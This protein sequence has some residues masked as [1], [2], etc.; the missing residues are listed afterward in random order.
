MST[1]NRPIVYWIHRQ[2][3]VTQL[4]LALTIASF[5][6]GALLL[7]ANMI[8][9]LGPRGAGLLA[10]GCFYLCHGIAEGLKNRRHADRRTTDDGIWPWDRR[11][12]ELLTDTNGEEN[13]SLAA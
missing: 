3:D 12:N 8:V 9:P 4:C 1:I 2:S 10:V 7:I 11:R 5:L 6:V 13:G